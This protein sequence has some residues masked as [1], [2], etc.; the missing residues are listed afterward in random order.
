MH[1][2]TC[3]WVKSIH[4]Y[5][6]LSVCMHVSGC[7]SVYTVFACESVDVWVLCVFFLRCVGLCRPV[8]KKKMHMWEQLLLFFFN[9]QSQGKCKKNSFSLSYHQNP[10][11][12]VIVSHGEIHACIY[13]KCTFLFILPL[14]SHFIL[15]FQY[16]NLG[17][18][19]PL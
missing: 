19:Q 10:D 2:T 7:S 16:G 17:M 5:M 8:I 6:F 15:I 14:W 18:R 9:C 4:L 13:R 3:V 11:I 1:L 12:F